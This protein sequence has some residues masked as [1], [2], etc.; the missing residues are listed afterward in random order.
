MF[1][2]RKIVNAIVSRLKGEPFSLDENI[3]ISYVIAFFATK[4]VSLIFG[5]LRF[6]GVSFVHPSS[7]I[8]CSSKIK[9]GK[10]FSIGRNCYVD[11]LSNKGLICGDNVSMGY[12]THIELT[13]SMKL[14]GQGMIVGNNVGLGSHGHYGSGA[15]LLE[16]GDNTIFGNYVSVHPE[17]HNFS[18]LNMPIRSQGVNGKGVMIGSDCWIG[19]KVTILDGSV[20]GDHSIVAAGAVVTGKFPPYSI[21]GGVPAKIIKMRR[22]GQ[23]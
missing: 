18:D 1:V 19:A 9:F 8:K 15:G 14:L 6:G 10:N 23:K 13:G 5:I 12:F 20:I 21:I 16:I 2:M 22:I 4:V 11:A 7:T 17:N 3:P